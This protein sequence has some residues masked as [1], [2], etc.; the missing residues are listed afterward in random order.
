MNNSVISY[1]TSKIYFLIC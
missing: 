1:L